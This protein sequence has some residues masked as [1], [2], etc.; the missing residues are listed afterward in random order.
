MI[1]AVEGSRASGRSWRC[2]TDIRA[3]V[4]MASKL[5]AAVA[6][7]PV[8]LPG[9]GMIA[10]YLHGGIEHGLWQVP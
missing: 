5:G 8:E 9:Q 2:L 4:E 7:E 3:S 6:L 1:E 10:I